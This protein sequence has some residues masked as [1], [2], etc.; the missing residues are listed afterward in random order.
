MPPADKPE[1]YPH[2]LAKIRE[3]ISQSKYVLTLHVSKRQTER[4]LSLFDI[5][6]VLENGY[7]EK[8]KTIFDKAIWRWKYAIRGMTIDQSDIRVIVAFDAEDLII[9][10]SMHVGEKEEP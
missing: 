3:C 4:D 5:L 2:L 10:T 8:R 1:Q 9:I 6:H 7:H